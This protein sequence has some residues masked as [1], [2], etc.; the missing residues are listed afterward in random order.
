MSSLTAS[1]AIV[2]P[3][4]AWS[5]VT[6][7]TFGQFVIDCILLDKITSFSVIVI[8]FGQFVI[9]CILLDKITSL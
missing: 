4:M 6:V 3:Y 8:T 9:D 2:I 1:K 7:I 5:S